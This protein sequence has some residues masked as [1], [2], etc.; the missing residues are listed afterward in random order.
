MRQFDSCLLRNAVNMTDG[1]TE[2]EYSLSEREK[3]RNNV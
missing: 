2:Y 3:D 1:C